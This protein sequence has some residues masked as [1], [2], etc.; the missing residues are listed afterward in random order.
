[1]KLAFIKRIQ[2]QSLARNRKQDVI[3]SMH[4]K[5]QKLITKVADLTAMLPHVC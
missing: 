2:V 5:R 4:L 1:M 3:D